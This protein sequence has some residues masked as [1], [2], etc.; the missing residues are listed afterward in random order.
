MSTKL[1]K[2]EGITHVMNE[3]RSVRNLLETCKPEELVIL[4]T[5]VKVYRGLLEAEQME[6]LESEF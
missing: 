5:K 4:Q 3:L 2:D 6:Q 1:L